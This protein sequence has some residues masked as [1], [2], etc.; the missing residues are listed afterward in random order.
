MEPIRIGLLAFPRMTQ[1]DFTGPYEVL[2]RLPGAEVSV[3]ARELEPVRSDLGLTFLP[4]HTWAGAPPLDVLCVPGGPGVDPL[5]EDDALLDFLAAQERRVKYL[6]SVCTGS[7]LLGAAGLLRGYRA[8]SHWLSVDLL[9]L[10]GATPVSERVVTDR[11]RIT[12]GGV[13]AGI[14]FGLTLLAALAGERTARIVSLAIEYDPQP[15]F[16]GSPRTADPALVGGVAMARSKD[17][18]RR[19]EL[20]Q[21]AVARRAGH[22]A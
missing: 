5:L 13:T 15:P 9:P 17:Q 11:N 14:D 20:C 8:T 3:L 7:L 4:T 1:L 2:A 19:R 16:P 6:T 10:F 12:G 22:A 21:Q 18:E